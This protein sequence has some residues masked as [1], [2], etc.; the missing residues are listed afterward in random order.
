MKP[1]LRA[2]LDEYEESHQHPVNIAIH[3]VAEPL[4]I[5]A[6]MALIFP[7]EIFGVT[8]LGLFVWAPI[9]YF[10]NLSPRITL[11]FAAVALVFT[12]IIIVVDRM[13]VPMWPWALGLFAVSWVTLLI[14][15]RIEGRAPSVFQNP[16]LIIIGPLWLAERIFRRFGWRV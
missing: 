8:A 1:R 16:G 10:A 6:L 3:W 15:H 12:A 11:M 9:Y 2:L 7:I 13:A 5:W 4:A 14:A